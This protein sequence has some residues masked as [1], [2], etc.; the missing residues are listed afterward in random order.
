MSLTKRERPQGSGTWVVTLH[1]RRLPKGRKQLATFSKEGPEENEAAADLFIKKVEAQ[2]ILDRPVGSIVETPT[3]SP[4]LGE[5]ANRWLSV[6]AEP[7]LAYSTVKASYRP[8]ISNHLVPFFS[9]ERHL[10]TI[11]RRDVRSFIAAKRN[12]G[13]ADKTIVNILQALSGTFRLAIEE[14]DN[15]A[16]EN[17]ALGWRLARRPT[18]PVFVELTLEE[19]NL[20]LEAATQIDEKVGL[21]LLVAARAGLR[22][23]EVNGLQFGD[24]QY[25]PI[26]HIH[27]RRSAGQGGVKPPKNNRPRRVDM[28]H[29][30]ADALRTAQVEAIAE[31]RG[32][33]SEFIFWR[34]EAPQGMR[35]RV[36]KVLARA[37]DL[38]GL[39]S[40]S[41][42]SLR[43]NF[44]KIH[45][46]DLESDVKWVS[47]QMGHHSVAFTIST[48]GCP[49]A[50]SNVELADRMAG[51]EEA[52]SI[53][54]VGS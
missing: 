42:H 19:V 22:A 35:R 37:C 4:T 2:L 23:G 47:R 48:Y 15:I 44:A 18:G 21:W 51:K 54:S 9:P 6:Y 10:D 24:V 38:A 36:H 45:I 34:P 28:A 46:W 11:R 52:W 3:S 26:R 50:Y 12:E 40:L 53:T 31:G 30:L 41:P 29:D 16:L 17:P 33:P 5:A 1:D 14:H 32:Q 25:E 49:E 43:H 8:A 13:L 7:E 39:P 27:V 20:L